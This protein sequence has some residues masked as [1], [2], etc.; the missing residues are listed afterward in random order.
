MRPRCTYPFTHCEVNTPRG[1]VTCCCYLTRPLGTVRTQALAE[2]WNGE[3]WQA[4]RRE[5]LADGISRQCPP[6][7]PVLQG[8]KEYEQLDWYGELPESHPAR[9]N[10]ELNERETADGAVV[11]QS[12]P[13]WL[14]FAASY[15]CNLR[16]YHCYQEAE[17]TAGG[18]LP[19]A[20]FAQAQ[21]LLPALQVLFLYG[22]EPLLVPA[23]LALLEQL[24][25]GPVPRVFIVTNGTV[26]T[27]RVRTVLSRTTLGL[28]AVSLDSQ[29]AA[30][31]AELRTPARWEGTRQNLDWFAERA[32]ACAAHFHLGL[33][34]NRE[35]MD[36]LAEFVRFARSLG[37]VPDFQFAGDTLGREEFRT[38]YQL[39]RTDVP[40]L[41]RHLAAAEA[42]LAAAD[43]PA[44]R[45]NLQALAARARAI[46]R[47]PRL[48]ERLR[49]RWKW[50]CAAARRLKGTA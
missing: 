49:Y 44:V 2:I 26:L 20:F 19:A 41:L 40:A 21:A 42:E 25:P 48:Q 22:G 13:R 43:D 27:D 5:F 6:D 47:F 1:D 36:E 33:T 15:A 34:V 45:R 16:C 37:A 31:Y 38:R 30:R 39:R 4:L 35:N 29:R 17:R 24:P 7:C 14:R 46:P 10:A 9:I 18:E 3:P 32:R 28:L 12:Q 50:L 23:N 11:L 8:W